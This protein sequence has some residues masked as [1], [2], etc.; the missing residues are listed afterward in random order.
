MGGIANLLFKPSTRS[1]EEEF[2]NLLSSEVARRRTEFEKMMCDGEDVPMM[3]RETFRLNT[4]SVTWL[5]LLIAQSKARSL[6]ALEKIS[7][8][9]ASTIA[10]S[11]SNKKLDAIIQLLLLLAKQNARAKEF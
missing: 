2:D 9:V 4:S 8:D 6:K 5:E 11:D 10:G 7:A 1:S 3:Y